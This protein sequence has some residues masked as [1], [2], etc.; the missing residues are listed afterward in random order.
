MTGRANLDTYI[1]ANLI[2]IWSHTVQFAINIHLD[3]DERVNEK[4]ALSQQRVDRSR[5]AVV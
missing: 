5:V 2:R 3:V 1:L 4:I